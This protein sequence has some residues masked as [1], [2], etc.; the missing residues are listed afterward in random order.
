[1]LWVFFSKVVFTLTTVLAVSYQIRSWPVL[2]YFRCLKFFT[3][4]F[5]A[6]SRYDITWHAFQNSNLKFYTSITRMR[7]PTWNLNRTTSASA[8]HFNLKSS[9]ESRV[10]ERSCVEAGARIQ[11]STVRFVKPAKFIIF[12]RQNSTLQREAAESVSS[13]FT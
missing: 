1:M 13:F 9:T 7:E 12:F 6:S 5:P 3:H 10:K 8:V 4:L 2:R 11:S